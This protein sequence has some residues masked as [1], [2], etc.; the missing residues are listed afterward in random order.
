MTATFDET[1]S[2]FPKLVELAREGASVV[3]V[4]GKSRPLARIVPEGEPPKREPRKSG[5][6]KGTVLYMAPDS[7]APMTD[8]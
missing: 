1:G 8:S 4:D 6:L 3:I 2:Q 7:N 5:T